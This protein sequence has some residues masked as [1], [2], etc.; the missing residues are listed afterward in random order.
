MEEHQFPLDADSHLRRQVIMEI[1]REKVQ[2]KVDETKKQFIKLARLFIVSTSVA[3]VGYWFF[4]PQAGLWAALFY[5]LFML[6]FSPRTYQ[7]FSMWREAKK[8]KKDLENWNTVI[9]DYNEIS[10]EENYLL[11]R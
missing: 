2:T 9:E 7:V 4:V 11:I 10:K 3:G 1:E 5:V 8:A 6:A